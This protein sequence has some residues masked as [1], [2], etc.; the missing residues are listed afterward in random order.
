M[1]LGL[2]SFGQFPHR[3]PVTRGET[4]DVQQQQVL[5]RRDA[6]LPRHL[7][8][9]AQEA[10]QLVAELRKR[11]EFA[12]AQAWSRHVRNIRIAFLQYS[13]GGIVGRRRW[14]RS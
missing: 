8:A 9:E 11:F 3:S 2:Q 4:L 6:A 10:A 13:K 5:Q 1:V 14:R 7:F 12:L